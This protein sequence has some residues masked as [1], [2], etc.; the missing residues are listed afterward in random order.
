M[1]TMILLA[2][3]CRGP[4]CRTSAF[5]AKH[6]NVVID[7]VRTAADAV[8]LVPLAQPDIVVLGPDV[9]D[10]PEFRSAVARASASTRVGVLACN[11]AGPDSPQCLAIRADFMSAVAPM[12][13][14]TA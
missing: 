1:M 6:S 13:R 7:H 2:S 10:N 5:D 9:Q 11:Q 12:L 4:C 3:S 14:A 8:K